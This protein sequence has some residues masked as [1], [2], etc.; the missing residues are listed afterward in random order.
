[1]VALNLNSVS[2]DLR[3]KTRRLE[4]ENRQ[5]VLQFLFLFI[6]LK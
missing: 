2:G 3:N 6:K 4:D 5:H 1:M